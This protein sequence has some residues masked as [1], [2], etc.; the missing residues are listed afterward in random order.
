MVFCELWV[1]KFPK[2][3]V[4]NILHLL[5]SRNGQKTKPGKEGEIQTKTAKSKKHS[6]LIC[7]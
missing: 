6:L 3:A 7:G 4:K 1:V 2:C 5:S